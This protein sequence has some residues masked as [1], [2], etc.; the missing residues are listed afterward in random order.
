MRSSPFEGLPGWVLTKIDETE[1][2]DFPLKGA[3]LLT[4]FYQALEQS[5]SKKASYRHEAYGGQSW[6]LT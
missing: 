2:L 4:R 1:G 6:R 3:L 5:L